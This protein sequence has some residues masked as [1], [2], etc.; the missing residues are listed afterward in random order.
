MA[1]LSRIT[2]HAGNEGERL[3]PDIGDSHFRPHQRQN[4]GPDSISGLTAI[5]SLD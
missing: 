1:A 3:N 4:G 2:V 5:V